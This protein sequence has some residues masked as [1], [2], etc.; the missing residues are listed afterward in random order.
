MNFCRLSYTHFQW[1]LSNGAHSQ[2]ITVNRCCL[3]KLSKSG[4]MDRA[5]Q[6]RKFRHLG[7][8]GASRLRTHSHETVADQTVTG[9]SYDCSRNSSKHETGQSYN[10]NCSKLK[11]SHRRRIPVLQT[12][13]DVPRIH[14]DG[15]RTGKTRRNSTFGILR[16]WSR[17]LTWKD[18]GL[19]RVMDGL[20]C[21]G[22]SLMA[23]AT[24]LYWITNRALEAGA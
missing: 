24:S 19:W 17:K 10:C 6:R 8:R 2:S 22:T 13:N 23:S 18:V 16:V 21:R 1:V 4:W 5:Y 7:A 20:V 11:T 15:K 14:G 3:F 9:Q 12:N